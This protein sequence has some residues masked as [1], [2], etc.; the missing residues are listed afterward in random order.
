MSN[1]IDSNSGTSMLKK[2]LEDNSAS[3]LINESISAKHADFHRAPT[4]P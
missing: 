1:Y 2:T 4:L 3:A